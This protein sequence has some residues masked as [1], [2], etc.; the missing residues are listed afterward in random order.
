MQK[1]RRFWHRYRTIDN[2]LWVSAFGVGWCWGCASQLQYYLSGGGA[3]VAQFIETNWEYTL[4]AFFC[5]LLWP[6]ATWQ[7]AY[8]VGASQLGATVY[9]ATM[10]ILWGALFSFHISM[11]VA[12]ALFLIVPLPLAIAKGNLDIG[13]SES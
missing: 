13:I 9:T 7:R 6:I 1:F 10:A 11:P 8:C 5:A 2:Y 3:Q 12:M 4:L